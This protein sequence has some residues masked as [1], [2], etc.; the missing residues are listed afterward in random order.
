MTLIRFILGKIILFLNAIFTPKSL[1]RSPVDQAR[2]DQETKSM[3]IYQLEAC[4][5]CV[6]VRR[7]VKRLGLNITYKDVKETANQEELMRG[8]KE[9]QVPC[10]KQTDANGMVTWMYES[11]AIIEFLQGKFL[12]K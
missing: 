3:E 9:D 2:V 8:G 1:E 5:F 7:E 12:A 11:S 4:P 10:L 6:K